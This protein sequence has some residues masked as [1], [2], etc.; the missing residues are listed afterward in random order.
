MDKQ[1][2]TLDQ[3]NDLNLSDHV[4]FIIDANVPVDYLMKDF[5]V[6]KSDLESWRKDR[7]P[8]V[9]TKSFQYELLKKLNAIRI[10]QLV[11]D[12]INFTFW[13]F[14][15]TE[16]GWHIQLFHDIDC[17]APSAEGEE[18]IDV[19]YDLLSQTHKSINLD[20]MGRL[21]K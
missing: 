10:M 17:E 15:K 19:L 18:L 1:Y 3:L 11:T 4:L 14:D 21:K 16:K 7:K 12:F 20:F 8:L 5:E 2:I 6:I 13:H 9:V